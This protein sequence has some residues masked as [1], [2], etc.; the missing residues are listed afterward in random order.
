MYNPI[1]PNQC[2]RPHFPDNFGVERKECKPQRHRIG[3]GTALCP[4][5]ALTV[6]AAPS[7]R[8]QKCL[9]QL[10]DVKEFL[11][12]RY[13]LLHFCFWKSRNILT[14]ATTSEI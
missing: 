1:W 10:N 14:S 13:Y 8:G 5:P 9:W 12:A 6:L 2:T 7:T 3:W 11:P 4:S